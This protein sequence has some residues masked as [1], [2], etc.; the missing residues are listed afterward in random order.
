MAKKYEKSVLNSVTLK[1]GVKPHAYIAA[2]RGLGIRVVEGK[3]VAEQA[4]YN[5]RNDA[6]CK[7]TP[8]CLHNRRRLNWRSNFHKGR[9]KVFRRPLL[10]IRYNS[11]FA[12]LEFLCT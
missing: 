6:V 12:Y 4:V 7:K 3:R 2:K 5:R 8:H 10:R 1:N 11:C 9:L